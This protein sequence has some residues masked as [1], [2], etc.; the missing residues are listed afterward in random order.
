LITHLGRPAG[1]YDKKEFTLEPVAAALQEYL[2][3]NVHVEFVPDCVGPAVEEKINKCAPGT[4]F[5]CENLRFHIEEVGKGIVNDEEV[6]ATAEEIKEFRRK[7]SRLGDCFVF[8][9]YGAAHRPHS[10]IVGIDIS[11][12]V[13]GINM[14]EELKGT[15]KC[16]GNGAPTW[17]PPMSRSLAAP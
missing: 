10:S 17:M 16:W 8:E 14:H 6:K 3:S 5:L 1:N 12:R 2:S 9:A 7:L 11:E 4:V 13:A 15:A